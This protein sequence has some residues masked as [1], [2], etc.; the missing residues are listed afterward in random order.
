MN[1]LKLTLVLVFLLIATTASSQ[2]TSTPERK[3]KVPEN[4]Y[5]VIAVPSDW[6]DQV[7][8]LSNRLP[9][10]IVFGPGSG[11]SFQVLITP[12]RR[13]G[14]QSLP[15]LRATVERAAEDAKAQSV[16]K[17]LPIREFQGRSGPGYH[18][19]STD[20]A[21][22]PGE[23]KF[24]TQGILLV[25]DLTVTFTILTNEGQEQVVRQALDGLK[26]AVQLDL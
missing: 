12:I 10:T 22:K 3:F 6:T 16:E 4:G 7:Q 1:R 5:F 8:Q 21:P 2:T 26:N 9:P 25:G 19:S 18:F 23:Y 24:L 11:S 17:A 20:R 15:Q 14:P 13:P